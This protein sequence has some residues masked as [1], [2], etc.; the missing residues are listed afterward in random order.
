MKAT[1][2]TQSP[3]E[4]QKVAAELAGELKGGEEIALIGNL[5]AGKTTFVQGL[6][7]ALG[8][9]AKVKSPTFTLM[10]VYPTAHPK[11]KRLVHIDY[12]RIQEQG[13]SDLGL[14]EY[15]TPDTVIVSEWPLDLSSG[16]NKI[17]VRFIGNDDPNQRSITIER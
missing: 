16:K 5:G 4:T 15:K 13:A 3:E 7:A 10:H 14:D 8:S 2:T 1:Y 9:A 6:A 11:I 17:L 12:Y